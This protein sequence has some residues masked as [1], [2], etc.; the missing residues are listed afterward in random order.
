VLA[1]EHLTRAVELAPGNARAIQRLSL[2]VRSLGEI[3]E[4]DRLLAR[5]RAIDPKFG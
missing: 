4:A 2:V 3:E 1:R 5:A